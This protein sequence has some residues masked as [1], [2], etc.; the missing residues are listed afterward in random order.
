MN[1]DDQPIPL[2]FEAITQVSLVT[3]QKAKPK[4]VEY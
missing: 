4:S 1:P 3:N 2:E